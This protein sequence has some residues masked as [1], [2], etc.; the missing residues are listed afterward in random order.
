MGRPR[1]EV[2]KLGCMMEGRLR[3]QMA[4]EGRNCKTR[5]RGTRDTIVHSSV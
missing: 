2:V 5:L 1:E 3:A 4:I